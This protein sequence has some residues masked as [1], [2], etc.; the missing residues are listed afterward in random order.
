MWSR[1][2][3]LIALILNASVIGYSQS[4][5]IE[6]NLGTLY[7]LTVS[8]S[9][10]LQRQ[11]IQYKIAE[12]DKK[13]A[14]ST[15]DYQLYSD[16]S[17]SRSGLNLFEL[18][19]RVALVG[20]QINT[21][22]L[23]LSG[24]V[25]RTFRSG[26]RANAGVNYA[27]IADNFPLNS[28]NEDVGSFFSDNSTSVSASVT[29]PLLKGRGRSIT[30]ANETTSQ[31]AIENQQLN[32]TFIASG[33]IFNM[34]IGYWQYLTANEALEVY[35]INE[36]R[37]SKVLE[38]TNEL[39]KADK[40]PASDLLQV[41]A[42]LK[43]KERRTILAKQQLYAA[44]QN[45]GR[46]IGLST[47][48]SNLISLPKNDFPQIENIPSDLSLQNLLDLAYKN[49]T[50]LKAIK[51]S[52]E[53]LSVYV[54]VAE[55]NTKPQLD[56]TGSMAYG[57]VDAGNGVHRLLSALAQNE[58][59]NYQVALGLSYLFPINNNYAEANLLNSQL[60]YTDQEIQLKNQLR[61]IEVNVSIAYNDLL[62][63]IEAVKKSKQS[64][65]YYENV[66]KNEQL[67]FQSGLTTLLNLILLQERLTFAQLD[68]IQNQQQFAIAISNLRYETGTM[69]KKDAY[70]FISEEDSKKPEVF[71]SLPK[72]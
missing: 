72:E 16:L 42:D 53:I 67:K 52:L 18:D 22:N 63:S 64:L 44:R 36:A 56:L 61:N 66:F 47:Q 37:V 49:R 7:N 17:V 39:V 46:Y 65:A 6:C 9:P 12:V 8:K 20:G 51:K 41:Q 19:P 29:Q 50:D 59:R 32:T 13:S 60:L 45:L 2:L 70:N 10:T 54:D 55:N 26:L 71:Y 27:R 4:D 38:I 57:G 5:E 14:A 15:F 58:G 21:N 43:D 30:T 40:K 3:L 35:Q 68:Y 24:G 62:N 11:N 33:E 1:Y 48:E 69:Y 25:Q 23:S 34:A 31:L 28:F